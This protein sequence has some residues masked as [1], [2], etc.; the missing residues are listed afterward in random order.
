MSKRTWED[1]KSE[2][3]MGATS[4]DILG[5][6]SPVEY[7]CDN[8]TNLIK[9]F[10]SIQFLSNLTRR[11]DSDDNEFLRD[12]LSDIAWESVDLEDEIE[13]IRSEI[14]KLREWGQEWKELAKKLIIDYNIDI[15]DI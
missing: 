7:Q 15:E 1:I 12:R 6:T 4:E 14:E 3:I 13:E 5:L 9:K 11:D 2:N 10:N 8:I